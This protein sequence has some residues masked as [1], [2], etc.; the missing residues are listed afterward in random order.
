MFSSG[1]GEIQNG[2]HRAT[3][4]GQLKTENWQLATGN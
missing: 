1:L 4:N 2:G 3:G